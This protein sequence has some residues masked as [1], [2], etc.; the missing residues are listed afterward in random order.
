MENYI[1]W[2]GAAILVIF[3]GL[4]FLMGVWRGLKRSTCH[5][6]FFIASIIL[7]YLITKVVTN[8]L[9]GIT[10]AYG[11]ESYSLK[12]LISQLISEQFD[13]S[14]YSSVST[15][16]ENLPAAILSPIVFMF[17]VIV[18]Y[19]VVNLIYHC[20][21][22]FC[23]RKK[24][25]KQKPRR[26]LGGLLGIVE[27]F[28][29][30]IVLFAPITALTNFYQDLSTSSSE[31][32][33]ISSE[34]SFMTI[35]EYISLYVPQTV[36]DVITAYNNSF[37][38]K[39]VNFGGL[40][41][42]IFDGLAN[43]SVNNEKI[44]IR[45]EL[46]NLAEI[47]NNAVEIYGEISNSN[48]DISI[49]NLK[50]SVETFV[51]NGLFKAVIAPTIV[52]YIKNYSLSDENT[53]E[54]SSF[55]QVLEDL[56]ANL[57]EVVVEE[58]F[59][60]YTYF[61]HDIMQVFEIANDVFESK[62]V[63][64]IIDL[65]EKSV[66]NILEIVNNESVETIAT[67]MLTLNI[68]QD[69][70][71]TIIKF[72]NT[73]IESLFESD[74]TIGLN[75]NITDTEKLVSDIFEILN[76]IL[77]LYD[78]IDIISLLD[79]DIFE[80][81][82]QAEDLSSVLDSLG[83]VFDNVR[84]LELLVLDENGT[85]VYVF[86]NLLKTFEISLLGDEV[87]TESGSE[88]LDT[89]TK[90]FN[91]IKEPIM[92][93]LDLEILSSENF[94]EV[95]E[96]ILD[97]LKENEDLFAE[98]LMPFYQL[99]NATFD[100]ETSLKELVFDSMID[101]LKDVISEDIINFDAVE[102]TYESWKSELELLG[103]TLNAL[104]SGEIESGTEMTYL[105]YIQQDSFDMNTLL[106]AILEG[107][108]DAFTNIL[109]PI[110]KSSLFSP[111][112]E[113]V[114]EEID[115]QI[116]SLT[117]VNPQTSL[118]NLKSTIE[119][120]S[121]V[122]ETL[123]SLLETTL[124]EENMSEISLSTVGKI[125]DILQNNAKSSGNEGNYDGVFNNIFVNLVWY[126]TGDDISAGEIYSSETNKNE[127]TEEIKALLKENLSI[128]EIDYY[129]INFES[130]MSG[131]ED[132]VNLAQ[133]LLENLNNFNFSGE[134]DISTFVEKL[135]TAIGET[136]A[137]IIEKLASI[138]DQI[139]DKYDFI[140]ESTITEFGDEIVEQINDTFDSDVAQAICDLLGLKSITQA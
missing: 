135:E 28:V 20:V 52:D 86:D 136:S 16:I 118:D 35:D 139:E 101:A 48:Y 79:G 82:S 12:D 69:S 122:I 95:Y 73:Q 106:E 17:L 43:V 47:Y 6:F 68:V 65:E 70:F 60:G 126:L 130:A 105:E 119:G 94:D 29:F 123:K 1:V 129:K 127:Y 76:E 114:F 128:D 75:S 77:E 117:G 45:T 21:A 98:L 49:T 33:E 42:V 89:Y 23:F 92:T 74:E 19:F 15:F 13:L 104:N 84:E 87:Q 24:N 107:T 90:F 2:G 63:S 55:M 7:A 58:G 51:D 26:L 96:S 31:S 61:R 110:F 125:L 109:T 53:D 112:V 133:S 134:S 83:V 99:K 34:N 3:L 115:N 111:L 18:V 30:M 132:V 88:T 56:I 27:G 97:R 59:D 121:G 32:T 40:S 36:N 71:S 25:V 57:K 38:G 39:L 22:C 4:G 50:D 10:I 72:A 81:L 124:N 67:N 85:T 62:I 44:V 116:F 54:N 46:L 100:G 91:F 11:E 80:I 140:D 102:N 138:V 120:D 113:S 41:D 14:S 66:I 137:E 37:F 131:I 108:D 8:A 9:L 64:K 93:I 78:H 5:I 103:K